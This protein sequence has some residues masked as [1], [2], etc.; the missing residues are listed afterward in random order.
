MMNAIVENAIVERLASALPRSPLQ[1]NR[2]RESDAELIRLPGSDVVLA[3][4]TDGIVEEI[5][6]GLYDDPYLIGWMAV[7]VNA[8][9]LAAVGAEPIGLLVNET[10]PEDLEAEFVE[11][12]QRGIRDAC[13]ACQL[14]VL[15]GDTNFS[16]RMQISGTAVGVIS[17]GNPLTRRGCA[18]GD[19]LFASAPLGQGSAYALFHLHERLRDSG[20]PVDYRPC[21]RLPEGRVLRNYASCG[22][23]TSDGVLPTLDELM[24][25]N[26]VGLRLTRPLA[27]LLHR[28][29]LRISQAASLPAWTMLAGPHGEFELIFTVPETG[30]PAFLQAA[31]VLGWS[32]LDLGVVI[33]E[34]GVRIDELDG[35]A[36]LD[37]ARMRNLFQEVGGD[38][39]AFIAGL[40]QLDPTLAIS[41]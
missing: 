14:D 20:P 15:G 30:C 13:V 29:A 7:M 40:L 34:P 33:C 24:R 23:D 3:L 9:D 6:A 37:T 2:L 17:N 38:V 39:Q 18:P 36:I 35:G 32:P 10:L 1:L 26:N 25:L 27:Q 8:S 16:A 41:R 12:L 28:D 19:R 22:M 4:T 21:A 11:E 5:E 31:S